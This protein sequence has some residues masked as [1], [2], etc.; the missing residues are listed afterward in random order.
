[1]KFPAFVSPLCLILA[2]AA[3]PA[4]AQITVNSPT[5]GEHVS[6]PFKL[7]MT[8]GTCSSDPVSAVGYSLDNSSQTSHWNAQYIDGPVG[9]P[10]GWHTLH[11]KAWNSKGEVCVVD[12]SIDVVAVGDSG[13]SGSGGLS[14]V[15]SGAAK[16]GAIQT[17]GDWQKVH[18]GGTPGSS[19]GAMSMAS[20]PSVGGASRLFANEFHDYGGERYWAHFSDD[21]TS[22]NFLYD[23]WVYIDKSSTGFKN[24]EFDLAQTM[25][26]GETAMMAFQCDG[27]NH[28][29]DFGINSG[30][31]KSSNATWRH[32]SA[33]C[34]PQAWGVNQW[35]HVQ[36]YL[37]R[38]TTGWITYHAVWLDGKEQN[39]DVTAFGGFDLGWGPAIITQFQI[40]G[41]SSGTTWGNVYLDELTVYRW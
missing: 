2:L 17:L 12:V 19:S 20:S 36:I 10:G 39:I 27:W 16:I 18:D 11:V 26:N 32:A 5:N 21:N 24:L 1:M 23:G 37:S 7:D 31:A 38:N 4:V 15:P 35:H 9:A 3:A 34:D 30:S 40:D 41:S 33:Y 6:S 22:E 28:T 25:E 8:A 13:T 29:W 14:V